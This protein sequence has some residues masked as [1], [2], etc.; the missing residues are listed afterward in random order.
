MAN[1]MSRFLLQAVKKILRD[2]LLRLHCREFSSVP[3]LKYFY[4]HIFV[5]DHTTT[6]FV[7]KQIFFLVLFLS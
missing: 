2:I 1:N 7:A 3:F 5:F 4:R 6:L